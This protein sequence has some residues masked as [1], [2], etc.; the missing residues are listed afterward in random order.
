MAGESEG[1]YDID[2]ALGLDRITAVLAENI[3]KGYTFD[4]MPEGENDT[5][6]DCVTRQ[7][8]V[9]H[10]NWHH[11]QHLVYEWKADGTGRGFRIPK[12]YS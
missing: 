4:P 8:R 10:P 6:A 7:Y 9:K 2:K 12:G 11:A 5:S 1:Q 3:A